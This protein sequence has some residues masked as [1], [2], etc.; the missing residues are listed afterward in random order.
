M[1]SEQVVTIYFAGTGNDVNKTYP[2][3]VEEL[4]A[5]LYAS[6]QTPTGHHKFFVNGI[7]SGGEYGT[8]QAFPSK[9]QWDKGIEQAKEYLDTVSGD[10]I[11]NVVGYSRG[12]ISAMK[13]AEDMASESRVKEINIL[14]IDPVIGELDNF[15]DKAVWGYDWLILNDKVKLYV[16]IYAEDE[17][18]ADFDPVKPK[19]DPHDMIFK[20]FSVP[21]SH[22]TLVGS[23][24]TDGHNS[25]TTS[26]DLQWVSRVTRDI[27]IEVLGSPSCG[28]V[29]FPWHWYSDAT[30][31]RDIKYGV[32]MMRAY[33]GYENMR[34]HSFCLLWEIGCLLKFSSS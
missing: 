25:T 21:G 34:I 4:L 29:R 11:L 22:E 19:V 7:G 16:G 12:G 28:N 9:A 32:E 23:R 33:S 5:A 31:G 8:E 3:D 17:R 14:A 20:T 1:W 10:V 18:S 24:R 15:E 6:Q 13:M 26:L 27:T 2:G 30:D